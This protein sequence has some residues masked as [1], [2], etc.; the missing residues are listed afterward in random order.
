[1]STTTIA[2]RIA[3]WVAK[4]QYEDLPRR[5]GEE[6]KN[7][8]LSVIA[9]VHAGHFSDAGRTVS[10]TV[11]EWAGGK[12]ATLIPSGERTS[13]HYAIFGNTALS[14]A[15]DYDDYLLRRRT[16]ATRRC[17]SRWR[18]RRRSAS[19]ARTSCWRRCS[20]T[21]WRAGSGSPP[22]SDP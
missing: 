12:E 10:R 1:M 2:D 16:P 8:I 13:V 14:M 11:K 17:S 22:C 18:W 20:P 4:A 6:A 3:D 15:L 7:Q 9:S 19:A 21:R 5:V